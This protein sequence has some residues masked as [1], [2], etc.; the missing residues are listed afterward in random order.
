[1]DNNIQSIHK[2]NEYVKK[3]K[4]IALKLKLSP[5]KSKENINLLLNIMCLL[6][7]KVALNDFKDLYVLVQKIKFMLNEVGRKKIYVYSRFLNLLFEGINQLNKV[8]EDEYKKRENPDISAYL[9][10]INDFLRD[11]CI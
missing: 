7:K 9:K 2:S 4:K 11:N 3:I 6:E 5:A 10:D 8:I 1:M